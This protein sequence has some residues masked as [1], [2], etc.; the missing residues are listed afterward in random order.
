MRVGVKIIL[1]SL[2]LNS[3]F[4]ILLNKGSSEDTCT[5]YTA[6][7]QMEF[8]IYNCAVFKHTCVQICRITLSFVDHF[9]AKY[10]SHKTDRSS[11]SA[12]IRIQ[13]PVAKQNIV[14]DDFVPAKRMTF[15]SISLIAVYRPV[16]GSYRSAFL[17]FF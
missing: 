5:F 8:D 7:L 16:P 9:Q 11:E 10:F 13:S 2:V 17:L 12:S 1:G 15:L 3:V 4:N 6:Q 14:S